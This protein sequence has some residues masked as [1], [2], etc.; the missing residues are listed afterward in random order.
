MKSIKYKLKL[1]DDCTI[2]MHE[3]GE[4]GVA[5]IFVGAELIAE[6]GF[7]GAG[8]TKIYELKANYIIDALVTL[9]YDQA[10]QEIIPEPTPPRDEMHKV[11]ES[12]VSDIENWKGHAYQEDDEV[13]L[14]IEE[15]KGCI[16]KLKNI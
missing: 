6:Y 5:Q 9:L 2:E 10:E 11:L 16:D 13:G 7:S 15:I 1:N 3:F 8:S 12:A 14:A 4:D